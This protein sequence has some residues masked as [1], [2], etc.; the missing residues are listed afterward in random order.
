M[1]FVSGWVFG[2]PLEEGKAQKKSVRS[3]FLLME[4]SLLTE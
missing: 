4:L 1:A 3:S 2:M